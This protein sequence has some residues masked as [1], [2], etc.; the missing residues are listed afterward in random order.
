MDIHLCLYLDREIQ[1]IL[2]VLNK[3]KCQLYITILV[4]IWDVLTIMCD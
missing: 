1:N 2:Y 4:N 3:K